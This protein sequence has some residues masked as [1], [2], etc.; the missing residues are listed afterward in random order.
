MTTEQAAGHPPGRRRGAPAALL[1]ACH[2]APALLVTAVCVALAASWG[3]SA[4]QVAVIGSAA[5][6]GQ[7]SV[8][9]CNDRV[10]VVRDRAAGRRDK[11]LAAGRLRPG[12]VSAAA[13]AALAAC[14]PLSLAAGRAAGTAHLAAVACAWA[15]NLWLKRTVWS[16]LPYAVAFALLPAFVSLGLPG[17]PWPPVWVWAAGALLGVGAHAANVL[18]DIRADLAAGVRGLPQ[19][20][21]PRR[22]RA[23]TAAAL[24][25]ASAAL[26]IGPPGPLGPAGWAALALTGALS[27]AAG[28]LP[29]AEGA[30]RTPFLAALAVAAVD[31]ALLVLRGS[32]LR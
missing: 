27:V 26:L 10:D 1:T 22:S 3:R 5:L 6:A 14:V 20:L 13:V 23:L 25:A 2:P 15:Y 29:G 4:E 30:G 19:R 7:L 8:G 24:L 28:A 9:W 16:A 12:T 31:V 17:R 11:P 21:G 18:P 32:P